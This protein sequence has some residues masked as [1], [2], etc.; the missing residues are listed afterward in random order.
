MPE[1][2]HSVLVQSPTPGDLPPVLLPKLQ[3]P[4]LNSSLVVRSRLLSRLDAGFERR[5]SLVS[6]PAG[7]GKTTLVCQWITR[8]GARDLR[9][10]VAWVSLDAGDNDPIR[11]WLYLIMACQGLDRRVGDTSLA[12]LLN[13][14]NS[15]AWSWH[16][17]LLM[18]SRSRPSGRRFSKMVN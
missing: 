12:I 1:S 6:A 8:R 18:P 4:R 5:L 10:R 16:A 14:T 11:F 15:G 13:A 9:R 7:Y 3:V 17:H 2:S